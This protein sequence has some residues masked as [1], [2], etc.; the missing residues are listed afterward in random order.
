M[1]VRIAALFLALMA[2][3]LFWAWRPPF[4]KRDLQVR[5]PDGTPASGLELT[6]LAEGGRMGRANEVSPGVYGVHARTRAVEVLGEAVA[7]TLASFEALPASLEVWPPAT[8]GVV[9]S[10]PESRPVASL[11]LLLL[12]DEVRGPYLERSTFLEMQP[13]SWSLYE[14]E[15]AMNRPFR[16]AL[17]TW[18]SAEGGREPGETGWAEYPDGERVWELDE[19]VVTSPTERWCPAEAEAT[20]A[21]TDGE[22]RA[23]WEELPL[24]WEG[25]LVT[26]CAESP[27]ALYRAKVNPVLMGGATLHRRLSAEAAGWAAEDAAPG[28]GL[29]LDVSL[30]ATHRRDEVRLVPVATVRGE[31]AWDSGAGAA[32][33]DL[34]RRARSLETSTPRLK[35]RGVRDVGVGIVLPGS[36]PTFEFAG[37]KPG[38][39]VL[40]AD[41]GSLPSEPSR[42]ATWF[43]EYLSV[44]PGEE[45]DLGRLAVPESGGI[46]VDVEWT[47]STG[48]TPR[49]VDIKEELWLE[50]T[51]EPD[52]GSAPFSHRVELNIQWSSPTDPGAPAGADSGIPLARGRLIGLPPGRLRVR[53]LEPY[54]GRSDAG[55]WQLDPAY[56]GPSGSTGEAVRLTLPLVPR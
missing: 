40:L 23:R 43:A 25:F 34:G 55:R 39:Y 5:F 8:Y 20:Y 50:L 42:N 45:L 51:V 4:E 47:T 35:L 21:R 17:R 41:L 37:L 46:D 49:R 26:S 1:V 9:A 14:V 13:E 36:A 24:G 32:N 3:A 7:D 29:L 52:N 44:E 12:P 31:L 54:R 18:H 22:G 6:W 56:L 28:E 10:D 27:E 16:E 33:L 11:P 30:D 15:Y 38:D 19:D 53:P 2:V 48:E